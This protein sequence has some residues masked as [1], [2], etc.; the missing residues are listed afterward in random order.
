MNRVLRE[1]GYM[2]F[3]LAESGAVRVADDELPDEDAIFLA[4]HPSKY[5]ELQLQDSDQILTLPPEFREL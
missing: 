3:R 5:A 4:I 1:A 2:V